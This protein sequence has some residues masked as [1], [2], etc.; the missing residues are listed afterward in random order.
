MNILK[1]RRLRFKSLYCVRCE[2]V[3]NRLKSACPH[4][5]PP[6]EQGQKDLSLSSPQTAHTE[7]LM[8]KGFFESLDFK[9]ECG[10]SSPKLT[11]PTHPV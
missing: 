8:F 6:G 3:L 1:S 5:C 10:G 11:T 7:S 2:Q 9:R 4:H